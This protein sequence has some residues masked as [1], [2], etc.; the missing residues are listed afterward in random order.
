[1]VKSIQT[2]ERFFLTSARPSAHR[3]G[4]GALVGLG[5]I[6][7]IV[8]SCS[9]GSL[10]SG[11]ATTSP[12][13]TTTAAAPSPPASACNGPAS[14]N[15]VPPAWTGKTGIISFN[16]VP[17]G[18][19]LRIWPTQPSA[20]L[21]TSGFEAI[22][23]VAPGPYSYQWQ[24]AN[25]QD[26]SGDNANGNFTVSTCVKPTPEPTP[27]P[28]PTTSEVDLWLVCANGDPVP[29]AAEYAGKVHPLFVATTGGMS[30]NGVK[31][32]INAK[33]YDHSWSGPIQLVIC[34]DQ[35]LEI[36]VGSCGTYTRKTDGV[37]GELDQYKYGT[38]LRVV[39]ATTGKPL[40][41]KTIYGSTPSC[42]ESELVGDGP[43][44]KTYGDEGYDAI[45]QY[46]A[47]VSTQIP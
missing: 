6:A 21:L 22:A 26:I 35:T 44:W 1:M 8:T 47:S 30:A 5:L 20:L 28:I 15:G 38:V 37:T 11:G 23:L 42:S 25:G 40:Q 41:S 31:Y 45:N 4:T 10:P 18:W 17:V 46:A 13:G 16:G 12:S 24:D 19:K 33:W 14:F 39:I 3:R 36:K 32:A 7:L 2:V 34:V 43:P 29:A 27:T 9:A